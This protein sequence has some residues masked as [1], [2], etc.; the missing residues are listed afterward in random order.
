MHILRSFLSVK[1][2]SHKLSVIWKGPGWYPGTPRLGNPSDIPEVHVC[3]YTYVHVCMYVVYVQVPSDI[4]PY[5]TPVPSWVNVYCLFHFFVTIFI[6]LL[7]DIK[8]NVSGCGLYVYIIIT[9]SC[10]RI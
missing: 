10:V 3:I 1:T 5:D 7:L 2:V 8:K 9:Y 4:V 6:S